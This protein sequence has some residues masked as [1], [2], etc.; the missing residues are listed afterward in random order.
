MGVAVLFEELKAT[1]P[2]DVA[3]ALPALIPLLQE[4]R[5]YIRGEAVSLLITIDT[6]EAASAI[7]Q[8]KD[9]PDPQVAEMVWDYLG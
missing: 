6:P 5:T 7:K 3:L 1:N 8:L 9:D 4:K 2:E